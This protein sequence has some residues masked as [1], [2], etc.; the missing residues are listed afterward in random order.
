M[1]LVPGLF[2]HILDIGIRHTPSAHIVAGPCTDRVTSHLIPMI[3]QPDLALDAVTLDI[4]PLKVES[5][6]LINAFKSDSSLD[7]RTAILHYFLVHEYNMDAV[8]EVIIYLMTILY[9]LLIKDII[10]Y[11]YYINFSHIL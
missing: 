5:D 8:F 10:I 3:G 2:T 6:L 11:N 9:N 7:N 4:V 1:I